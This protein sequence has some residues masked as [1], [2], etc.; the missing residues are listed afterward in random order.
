MTPL[1]IVLYP[2]DG[3]REVCRPIDE[4]SDRLDNLIEEM[5]LHHVR[6]AWN[7]PR[8]PS[9]RGAGAPYRRRCV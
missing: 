3:L 9:S 2:D 4:M 5:F 6:S 8:R 1:D 7:R